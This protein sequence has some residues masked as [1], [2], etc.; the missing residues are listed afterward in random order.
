LALSVIQRKPGAEVAA[1][2]V[3]W[4]TCLREIIFSAPEGGIAADGR[5]FHDEGAYAHLLEVICGLDSP[6]LGE[7]EVMHQF[8]AFAAAIPDE[9]RDLKELGQRLMVDARLVRS[10]HLLGLGSR[11]Y[12]SAVRRRVRHCGRVAI[13][14]TGILGT[15]ILPYVAD[16]DR[17]VDVWG[18]RERLNLQTPRTTYRQ[19]G[20]VDA[21][22]V[23]TGPAAMVIAAPV[24][25]FDISRLAALYSD[26]M[27]LID[28]RAEAAND[29]PPT[30]APL[31]TLADVFAELRDAA[32]SNE[33]SVGLAREEIRQCALAYVS[34]EKVR[35]SGWHDLCA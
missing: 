8:K 1:G 16:Q 5:V 35:P 2:G 31:V 10:R 14:G 34:R 22:S 21:H 24:P 6:I 29:P 4:R 3:V 33:R 28:L 32:A 19:I 20:D 13:V 11:S 26:L 25:S 27:L 9:R 30:V 23:L 18:R 12:G 17:V 15:E 7:T